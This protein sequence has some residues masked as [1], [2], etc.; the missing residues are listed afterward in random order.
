MVRHPQY[1]GALVLDWVRFRFTESDL[2][3]ALIMT[4]YKIFAVQVT[5][6]KDL[7]D[8]LGDVYIQYT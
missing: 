2:L 7:I 8:D 6:E 1:F 3:Y 4:G 5:E